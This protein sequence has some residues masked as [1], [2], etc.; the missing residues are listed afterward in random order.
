YAIFGFSS[1][2]RFR[3]DLFTIKDFGEP[4]GERAQYRLGSL[5]P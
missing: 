1:E 2:G 4:Y 5:E 3:V